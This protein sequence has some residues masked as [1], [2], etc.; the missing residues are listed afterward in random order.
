MKSTLLLLLVS[1]LFSCK[2]QRETKGKTFIEVP[3]SDAYNMID[4]FYDR[5]T[6]EERI[7]TMNLK[8]NRAEIIEL[9]T[10]AG[11]VDTFYI[12][13]AAFDKVAAQKYADSHKVPFDSVINKPTLL[14]AIPKMGSKDNSYY[15]ESSICP[16]P[17]SCNRYGE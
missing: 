11:K 3:Q 1:F 7:S 9:L 8:F 10:Q 12:C 13:Y 15:M 17:R 4:Q 2:E 16:P 5:L 14:I 6:P